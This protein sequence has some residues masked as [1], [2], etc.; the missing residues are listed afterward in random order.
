[1]QSSQLPAFPVKHQGLEYS[2]HVGR[3]GM[4][5]KDPPGGRRAHLGRVKVLPCR[6]KVDWS[7]DWQELELSRD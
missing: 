2:S 7:R 4:E 1:M 3:G 5:K 6:W